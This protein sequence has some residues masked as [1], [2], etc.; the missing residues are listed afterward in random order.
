M[1]PLITCMHGARRQRGYTLVEIMIALVIALFLL[2]GLGT[3]VAGT[4]RTGTN[5][6]S[7]AQLQ[8]EQ[9]L[10]M[11]IL[12]DVIQSAGTFDTNTYYT[13]Q[14]A[15]PATTVAA[16]GATMAQGQII[17]GIHSTT[18][19]GDTVVVRYATNGSDGIINCVGASSTPGVSAT[20]IN[21]FFIDS[22]TSQL[23]CSPSGSATGTAL[24]NNV[25]NMQIW[26]G[27]VTVGGTMNSVD[28]YMTAS[29]VTANSAWLNVTSARVTLAF[30][31]PL[32]T[33][34]GQPQYVF[35]T[36]VIALQPRQGAVFP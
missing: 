19:P 35:F 17:T 21:Y 32:Y 7:L 33:Q 25:A 30:N 4:R 36:R 24:V 6:M 10:A 29:Q 18:L 20:Y 5:Q 23:R 28:T 14:D 22:A 26:Y 1:S 34:P 11:S 27:V 15:W 9:R 16:T 3:L 8:D 13:P 12:T 31:N 2:G